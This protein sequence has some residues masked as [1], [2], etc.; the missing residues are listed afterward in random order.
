MWRLLW[1]ALVTAE[2]S[3]SDCAGLE[4]ALTNLDVNSRPGAVT[5][6]RQVPSSTINSDILHTAERERR[7]R[8]GHNPVPTA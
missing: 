4:A 7:Q 2:M 5:R 1:T 3:P 8:F 6:E